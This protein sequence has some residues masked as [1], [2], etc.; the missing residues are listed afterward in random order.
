MPTVET[1]VTMD[2]ATQTAVRYRARSAMLRNTPNSSAKE[3]FVSDIEQV[4]V[5]SRWRTDVLPGSIFVVLELLPLGQVFFKEEGET[6]FG[7]LSRNVFMDHFL[8]VDEAA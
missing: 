2:G 3:K 5:G 7:L 6:N 8:M 1:H 4:T